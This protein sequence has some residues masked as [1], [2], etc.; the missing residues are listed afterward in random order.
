MGKGRMAAFTTAWPTDGCIPICH[1]GCSFY[2]FLV[3]AGDLVGSMWSH[4]AESYNEDDQTQESWNLAPQPPGIRLDRRPRNLPALSPAPSFLE[5]YGAWLYQSIIDF[6][7]LPL[8]NKKLASRHIEKVAN[9]PTPLPTKD[10]KYKSL[11]E[12]ILDILEKKK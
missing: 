3:T 8:E 1:E 2:T 4:T 12:K 10:V 11:R 7:E 5:W 9:V 6:V